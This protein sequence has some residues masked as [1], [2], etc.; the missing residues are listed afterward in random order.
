MN[1]WR[2]FL[3]TADDEVT[4]ESLRRHGRT[5][6]PLG[7]PTFIERLETDLGRTLR[8]KKPGPKPM[9]KGS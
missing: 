7:A 8:P 1:D 3:R 4:L 6:R 5:G 9:R 2:A